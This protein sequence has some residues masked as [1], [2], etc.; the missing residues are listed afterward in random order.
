DMQ[1]MPLL[2]ENLFLP[3][4]DAI[5]EDSLK[6]AKMMFLNYPNNP[7]AAVATKRFFDET[8]RFAETNDIC[9]VHDFAYGAIGF[10]GERPISFLETEGAKDN[11]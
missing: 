2:E 7:T 6:K 8:V 1:M 4:Y 3:D 9:V 10:D 11:G 5:P